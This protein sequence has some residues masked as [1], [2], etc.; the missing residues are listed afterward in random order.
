MVWL[1]FDYHACTAVQ[2]SLRQDLLPTAADAQLPLLSHSTSSCC[3]G[4]H[5]S[6]QPLESNSL[7]IHGQANITI[8]Q[9]TT[10]AKVSSHTHPQQ[11]NSNSLRSIGVSNPS[12]LPA[13]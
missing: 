9:N 3:R 5:E 10:Q 2:I 6:T 7:E 13:Q 1:T 4:I 11:C 8:A 12:L